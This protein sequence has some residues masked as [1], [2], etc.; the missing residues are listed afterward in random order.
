HYLTGDTDSRE[1]VIGLADWVLAM[2]DGERTL[3]GV[4][5]PGPTRAASVTLEPDYHGPGRGPGNSI[6]VLLDAY[7]ATLARAYMAKAEELV[8]RCIHPHD[9]VDAR[10]LDD[11]ERR[12]S[13]LVFLQALGKYLDAKRELGE[14]DHAFQ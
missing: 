3:L 5:D 7:A 6:A 11:P 13:Y 10:R 9:D 8:G 14:F 12:W 2:D 4:L 1:A